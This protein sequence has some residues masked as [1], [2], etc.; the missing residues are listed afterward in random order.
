MTKISWTNET[1]NPVTGCSKVSEGCKFCYAER[2][3][4]MR[5]W[6]PKPWTKENAPVNVRLHPERLRKP[7][8]YKKPSMVFVNSMS[9]LFH[10]LVP[11]DFVAKV[12]EVMVDLPQHTFQILTKRPERAASWPG[13]WPTNVWMGT[14]IENARW[15]GRIDA[16]RRCGAAVRF[17]SFEPLLGPIGRV[18]LS[19]IHW[20][21]VGGESGP[22]FRPMD[23][24][25]ARDLRDQCLAQGVA[26]FFKQDS[27][28]RT[29]LRPWLVEE[30]GSCFEWHQYPGRLTKPER[31]DGGALSLHPRRSR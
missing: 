29:E 27:G 19:G 20:A 2:I 25:W 12:F 3:S 1:W 30:D 14:S 26:F 16:I 10:E 31:V 21:I 18:D 28:Y 15:A 9:D 8:T 11:D 7:Y 4:L 17:I 23:M 6:S 24:A 5:G 22:N 13:P